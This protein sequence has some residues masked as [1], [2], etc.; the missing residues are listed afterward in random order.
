MGVVLLEEQDVNK[1]GKMTLE[2]L[3]L[4]SLQSQIKRYTHVGATILS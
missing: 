1:F 4:M 2:P 3:S